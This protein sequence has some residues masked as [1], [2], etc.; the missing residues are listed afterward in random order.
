MHTRAED[1]AAI[2]GAR[3]LVDVEDLVAT[4]EDPS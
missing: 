4:V 2:G 1:D 3:D